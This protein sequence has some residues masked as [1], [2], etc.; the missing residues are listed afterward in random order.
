MSL[1]N[2]LTILFLLFFTSINAQKFELGEVTIEELKEKVHPKDTSAVAAIL[3]KKG[4]V[5]FEYSQNEGFTTVTE[6]NTKLKIYKKGGYDWANH[7]ISYYIG[8]NSKER[9]SFSDAVTYNLVNGK[10]E[11][12][13]LKSDGEFDEKINKYW[14]RK[15]ITMPNV[16]EGSI[17]EFRYIIRSPRYRFLK[18]WSFQTSIPV[19]YSEYKTYIPEYF[20]YNPNQKGFVFPKITVGKKENHIIITSKER[21]AQNTGVKTTFSR[22]E[23]DFT[24]IQTTYVA[25]NLPAMKQEEYVNNIDNYTSSISHE[26]SLTKFPNSQTEL[27]STDWEA[28]TKTIYEYDDFGPEL[29]KTGYFE[30]ELNILIKGLNTPEEKTEAIFNFVKTKVKWNGYT[31]YSCNEGVK[32]AYKNKT[33]NVAEINLMLTAMLRH[34]GITANPVLVSTR[35]NGIAYFPSRT[36]FNYV[37]AGIENGNDL[38]LLDATDKFSKPNVLPLRDLNWFGRLIR[39]DGSS[40]EVNL[41]PKTLS[42]EATNIIVTLGN[43]GIMNGKIRQQ[44]S[45]YL[46]LNFRQN[47]SGLSND[48]YLT[49]LESKNNNIEITDYIRENEFN[50]S[51][52]IVETYSFKDT[53]SAEIIGDKIYL[54]PL[55]FLTTL[56]NPF[57]QEKREYPVD[58]GYPK[59]NKYNI[60]IEIPEGYVVESLPAPLNIITGEDNIGV[61]K[62]MI[63]NTE[64]KIQIVIT[65]DINTAI[66]PA[67]YYEI[68]KD[69][70]KQLID[71]QNEKI[72]LKKA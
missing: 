41:M 6:V 19:N 59:Q 54:S 24:E 34:A 27:F 62:Y 15:K 56:E 35:S 51:N 21:D 16:K 68:L 45:D 11:K 31:D 70:F 53:K 64:N 7:D 10:I 72:V 8:V 48:A 30:E 14:S 22:D 39:K 5:V 9:I 1:K 37:I 55:L 65:T 47:Y 17:I 26:L 13:K 50:L 42:K 33:G 3:F 63:S 60:G 67:D 57:K 28:V 20:V 61:F 49:K 29:N 23:I 69:F 2:T 32:I 71:K 43:D 36:A 52:P 40:V 18:D 66:V 38:I 46:A 12:V 58:F 44:S 25:E 4:K